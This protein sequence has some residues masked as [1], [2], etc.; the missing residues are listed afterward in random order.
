MKRFRITAVIPIKGEGHIE[1]EVMGINEEDAVA[2]MKTILS[3]ESPRSIAKQTHS[4]YIQKAMINGC[5]DDYIF[6]SYEVSSLNEVNILKEMP[7][8]D[9][10]ACDSGSQ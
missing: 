1:R 10:G 9:S 8:Y 7:K 4:K 2:N 6:Y 5:E 3:L